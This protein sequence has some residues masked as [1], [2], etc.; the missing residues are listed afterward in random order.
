[1]GCAWRGCRLLWR[2]ESNVKD[3]IC[4]VPALFG[5]A[6][7]GKF[8]RGSSW[9]V[10]KHLAVLRSIGTGCGPLFASLDRAFTPQDRRA[11]DNRRKLNPGPRTGDAFS[12]APDGHLQP[13]STPRL[14]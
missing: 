4:G 10:K 11:P 2:T 13:V 5:A 3:G 8:D 12:P 1:V 6:G 14:L 9:D 7:R